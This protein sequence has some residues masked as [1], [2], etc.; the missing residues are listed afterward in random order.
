M[1]M[2]KIRIAVFG[3]NRGI[4]RAVKRAIDSR[5]VEIAVFF[6]NDK[7]KQG[8][9][10][11]GI[12]ILALSKKAISDYSIE[13]VI[14]TALS[15]YEDIQMQLINLGI[16]KDKI[17]VFIADELCKYC[18][19]L[20]DNIDNE[21]IKCIYFEPQKRN[22][23]ITEY[24]KIY[25][26]YA[27]ISAYREETDAWFHKSHFISHACGGMVNG[28][29]MMYSNSK[30]AFQY[31]MEKGF[32]LI[33]CDIMKMD[34]NELILAHD[35]EQFYGAELEGYTIM[36]LDDLLMSLQKYGLVSCLID[37][38]WSNYDEY[39][40][41]V[42]EIESRIDK[43][44]DSESEEVNLKKQIIMEV[45]DEETIKIAKSKGFEMFFAQYRNENGKCFMEIAHLCYKY[46]IKAVGIPAE[47]SGEMEK[48]I[49]IIT[50][51]GIKIFVYSVDDI[52]EYSKVRKMNISGVFTNYLTENIAQKINQ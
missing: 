44:S 1:I 27:V 8:V 2:N 52:D 4:L 43:I 18:I 23:I 21:L 49:K 12:P 26:D 33:E 9:S 35:Y 7:M 51:K 29:R 24:N 22:D 41:L 10:Y 34:N 19:G 38:K 6:D 37:V 48:F 47:W 50:D 13:Y 30:E 3:I 39:A 36:T 15:A 45:Y 28:K 40:L 32:S 16:S 25:A 11:E 42:N 14:I 17:Q 46:G 31:S 20:I 5:R